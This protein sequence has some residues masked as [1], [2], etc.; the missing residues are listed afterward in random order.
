MY[1]IHHVACNVNN[2]FELTC[3]ELPWEDVNI[4]NVNNDQYPAGTW[5]SNT[6]LYKIT[7]DNDSE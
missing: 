2:Y 4:R 1:S 3:M 7:N 6:G 5:E